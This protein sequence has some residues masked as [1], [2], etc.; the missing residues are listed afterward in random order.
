[1]CGLVVNGGSARCERVPEALSIDDTSVGGR[2]C[3]APS[4]AN[5]TFHVPGRGCRV[6]VERTARA[7]TQSPLVGRDGEL[8][9]VLD[10][11]LTDTESTSVH[12]V[13]GGDAGVG[14]SRFTAAL[15]DEV[16]ARGWRTLLGHCLDFESAVPYLPFSETVGRLA[17]DEPEIFESLLHELPSIESL[18]PGRRLL[19]DGQEAAEESLERGVLFD[20]MHSALEQLAATQPT[21]LV[22]EDVHWG[23]SSTR[24]LLTVLL[25]RPFRHRV[26]I[27]VTYR[28][29]DLDRRHP[30]RRTLLEWGRLPMVHRMELRPLGDAEMQ[31]LVGHLDPEGT[32]ERV[33]E[34]ISRAEG[35][36]FFAEELAFADAAE[37]LPADLSDVLLMRLDHLSPESVRVVR[38]AAC[39]G[40]SVSHKLIS[41][42][43]GGNP[44]LV[45]EALRAAVEAHLLVP[46]GP[47]AYRF[48]HALLAEAIYE[49]LLPGERIRL[50]LSYT[51]ALSGGQ[52]SGTAAELARHAWL[53]GDRV[54]ALRAS[55][56]AGDEAMR[57]AGPAESARH[58][59]TALELLAAGVDALS[60]VDRADVVVRASRALDAA[61]DSGRAVTLLLSALDTT[62]GLD[63]KDRALLHLTVAEIT[64]DSMGSLEG[65]NK[66]ELGL[67]HS[68]RAL[69]LIEGEPSPL[70]ATAGSLRAR[71]LAADGR[72]DEAATLAVESMRAA[73]DLDLGSV[74]IDAGLTLLMATHDDEA[75][76]PEVRASL[77]AEI[78]EL[79]QQAAR[80]GDLDGQLRVL[81]F[82]S[83]IAYRHLD[84]AAAERF[85]LR[86]L[87]VAES[88]R[89][90]WTNYAV[91]ARFLCFWDAFATGAWDLARQLCEPESGHPPP[92][93][94]AYL[95][96]AQSAMAAVRGDL[97]TAERLMLRLRGQWVLADWIPCWTGA[98]ALEVLAEQQGLDA[99]WSW[100][101]DVA[102]ALCIPGLEQVEQRS[103]FQRARVQLAATLLAVLNDR[104]PAADRSTWTD[105]VERV[106]TDTD[107]LVTS[108]DRVDLGINRGSWPG[109]V[110]RRDAEA[111]VFRGEEPTTWP[112]AIAGFEVVGNV[113]E[114]A[115]S[116]VRSGIPEEV[117]RGR[118]VLEKIGAVRHAEPDIPEEALTSR[119]NEILALVAEGLS[120]G[121][122]GTR[123][124]ISS[125]TVSVHVSNILA[126]LHV[127]RRTEAAAHYHRNNSGTAG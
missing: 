98:L 67:E 76:W 62:D 101:E 18:L 68:G 55:L 118:G 72:F 7:P 27:A 96:S 61:G 45:D 12:Y 37:G 20:A 17:V 36:P 66:L 59:E 47:D 77:F 57:V 49:D 115:R 112:E 80:M 82:G 79:E 107:P 33:N 126:K 99:A 26:C 16:E 53:G 123:L 14:K 113:Y 39:A 120:N 42:V 46:A 6:M 100:Y 125:K 109:W 75:D 116:R 11:V 3:L 10:G 93:V 50:H 94:R 65:V 1:M 89:R 21:L 114:A 110:A 52:V 28:S 95:E 83:F 60:E 44:A 84:F 29:D 119:E 104:V 88:A 15:V 81:N 23:G 51:A 40:R 122:I 13:I 54:S 117:E 25:S 58:Y 41:A 48:R 90:P 64:H 34:I 86:T 121:E 92:A 73:E 43:V 70:L 108:R 74:R 8:A 106:L 103:E 111:A 87:D 69:S 32:V 78:D 24:D 38:A 19:G 85:N 97:E 63:D 91:I 31:R 127:H 124:F 2:L 4:V 56:V 102:N 30:V 105:R 22:V 9:A 71:L 5:P 35:N